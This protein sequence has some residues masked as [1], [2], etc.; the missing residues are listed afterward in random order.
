MAAFFLLRRSFSTIICKFVTVRGK[1]VMMD[2]IAVVLVD[3]HQIVCQGI[4]AL[5]QGVN[6]IVVREV[7]KNINELEVQLK[8]SS[9]H[10][11]LINLYN[12]SAEDLE[13]IKR[14]ATHFPKVRLLIFA[15]EADEH[16]ILQ[17]IRAGAKGILT[18]E[19]SRNEL[20]EAIYTVRNGYD[21]YDKTI[22]NIILH[23]YLK[24]NSNNEEEKKE[25]LSQREE[26]VL[27]LYGEGFTNKEIADKLFISIRTVETHKNNIMKKIN[28]RTTVDM[29]KFAI[30]NNYVDL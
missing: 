23:S 22:T 3:D 30:R 17:T 9:M 29:V 28:L 26:E 6:D 14:I 25:K 5:L 12:P 27:T 24:R 15:L 4:K 7:V 13:K 11:A 16:F 18:R 2:I 8:V 19:S 10:V 21:F 20:V 1:S